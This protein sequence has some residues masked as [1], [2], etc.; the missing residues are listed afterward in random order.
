MQLDYFIYNYYYPSIESLALTM[1]AGYKFSIKI[2]ILPHFGNREMETIKVIDI[3][4]WIH[5][6][7]K[8]GAAQKAYKTLRQ[9]LRKAQDYEMYEGNDPTKK[10]IK[11]PHKTGYKP[12]ILTK[13]QVNVLLKGFYGHYLE[14]TVL[15]AVTMGLR[16]GEAFGLTWKDINLETGEVSINKCG[17][18]FVSR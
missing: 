17:K 13:E 9:I 18:H 8:P 14:A 4:K 6:I 10:K 3:E 15:C 7:P 12:Y 11:I 2:Y 1:Q 5:S 16:R